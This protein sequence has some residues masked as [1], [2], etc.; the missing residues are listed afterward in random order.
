MGKNKVGRLDVDMTNKG[1][2]QAWFYRSKSRFYT[3]V[4]ESSRLRLNKLLEKA[5]WE[6]GYTL[7]S[8]LGINRLSVTLIRK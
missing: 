6:E 5:N 7:I 2:P 1:K 3:T 4:T 8:H